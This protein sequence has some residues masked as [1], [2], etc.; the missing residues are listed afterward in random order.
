VDVNQVYVVCDPALHAAS[1]RD[2]LEIVEYLVEHGVDVHLLSS[3]NYTPLYSA[4]TSGEL[5]VITYLV[6]Q[7]A[8]V[9]QGLE[10]AIRCGHEQVKIYLKN[11]SY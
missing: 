10:I 1:G 2:H 9:S 3:S 7:G 5:D 11:F 6:Q 8:D 4:A